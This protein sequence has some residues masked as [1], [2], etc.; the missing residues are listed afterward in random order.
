MTTYTSNE[1]GAGTDNAVYL[2][3]IGS[4]ASTS[5]HKVDNSGNDREQGDIDEY[6]FNDSAD[7]GEFQCV[8]IRKTGSDGWLI[9]KVYV[10]RLNQRRL[11][12][13]DSLMPSSFHN[14]RSNLR[15][16]FQCWWDQSKSL[17]PSK[18]SHHG[19]CWFPQSFL[20]FIK[21]STFVLAQ[22]QWPYLQAYDI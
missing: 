11:S 2:S 16:I 7:I 3:I 20:N 1:N 12:H 9:E 21:L 10:F 17:G 19:C 5:E 18:V 13:C 15:K 8:L 22:H 14:R 6:T 4:K